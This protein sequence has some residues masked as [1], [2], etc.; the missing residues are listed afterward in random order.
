[1]F[2]LTPC[3]FFCEC[4]CED[5]LVVPSCWLSRAVGRDRLWLRFVPAA[6]RFLRKA[7][8]LRCLNPF[9]LSCREPLELT[10][11]SDGC[12]GSSNDE[13]RSEVR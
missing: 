2:Q 7:I 1:M 13:G 4:L 10:T 9:L 11:F 12:L 8:A 3:E 5:V 6:I